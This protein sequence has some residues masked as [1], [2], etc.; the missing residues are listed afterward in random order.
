MNR[1]KDMDD[2]VDIDYIDNYLGKSM[3]LLKY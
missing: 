2:Y 3:E 1:L